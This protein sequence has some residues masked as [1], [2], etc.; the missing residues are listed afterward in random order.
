M[1]S[2]TSHGERRV[3]PS[4][5]KFLVT[6]HIGVS[7]SWLGAAIAK[8]VLAFVAA[9]TP[10]PTTSAGLLEAVEVLSLAYP[11]LAVLTLIS[12][13]LLSL[14]T[15]WGLVTYYWVIAKLV[16]TMAVIVTGIQLT[17]RLVQQAATAAW[18][19]LLIMSM[20]HVVMLAVATVLSV[21]K[22]WGTIAWASLKRAVVRMIRPPS[23]RESADTLAV[24][25]SR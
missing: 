19:P 8:L 2:R 15:R 20:A 25:D 22:P 10:V 23:K 6:L 1:F 24:W 18:A 21:Y 7:V 17:E 5:Y 11:P 14:G 3:S 9:R 13:I 16:L 4:V 12:G